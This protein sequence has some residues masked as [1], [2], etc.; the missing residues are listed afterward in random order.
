MPNNIRGLYK[1][2]DKHN[3]RYNALAPNCDTIVYYGITN[4]GPVH[5]LQK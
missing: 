2:S 1:Y 5:K 4:W 3:N